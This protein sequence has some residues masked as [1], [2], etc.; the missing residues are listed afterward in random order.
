MRGG[1]CHRGDGAFSQEIAPP[2]ALD[3]MTALH[4]DP[5]PLLPGEFLG[6]STAGGVF[7]IHSASLYRLMSATE[8]GVEAPRGGKLPH[9]PY[10]RTLRTL[11]TG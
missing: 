4:R 1:I 11:E 5:T 2:L 10:T 7:L 9:I 6:K 8:R 3:D